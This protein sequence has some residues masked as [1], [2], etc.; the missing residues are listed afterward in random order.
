MSQYAVT[1]PMSQAFWLPDNSV[2]VDEIARDLLK[3][4]APPT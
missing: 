2:D 1:N 3:R 4:K